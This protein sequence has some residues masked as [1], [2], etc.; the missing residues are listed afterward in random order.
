[1]TAQAPTSIL[2]SPVDSSSVSSI[3]YSAEAK[4]LE[5]EFRSGAVYRYFGVPGSVYADFLAASSKG[6]FFNGA[7]RNRFGY[8]RV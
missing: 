5:V 8:A 1:M 7:V 3:G 6:K 4:A 2:R